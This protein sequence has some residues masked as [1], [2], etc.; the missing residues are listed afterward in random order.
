MTTV[1]QFLPYIQIVLAILII[2]GVLLQQSEAGLGGAFGG[3]DGSSNTHTRRGAE[4]ML[5]IGT[6]VTSVLFI[7][8]CILALVI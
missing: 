8:S 5:F 7:A 4:K 6:I 1:L 3:S 2:G